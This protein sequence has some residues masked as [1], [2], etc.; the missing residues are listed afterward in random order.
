MSFAFLR[1]VVMLAGV[2]LLANPAVQA[3]QQTISIGTGGTGGVYYPLGG[4]MANLLSQ[5]LPGMQVT[6]EV[7]GASVDNLKFLRAGKMDVGFTMA[8]VAYD[9]YQ[10]I[11]KFKGSKVDARTLIS[12]Y[13]NQVQVVTVEG[14]GISKL[15]DLKGKR[16]STGSPGSGTEVLAFRMLE[17]VGIDKDK[18]IKRE[19]LSV[20]ESVNAIKDRKIDAFIWVGG[21]PTAAI[22]DLAA[23]PGVKIKLIDHAEV[24]D[25]MN[26]KYGPLYTKT[27]IPANSYQGQD[28]PNANI[29]VWNLLVVDAKMSNDMAYKITKTLMESQPELVNVHKEAM[30]IALK[31][32][33]Q[34]SP[35]PYHPGAKKYFEEKGVHVQ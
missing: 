2:L 26:K 1:R 18:D 13:P 32:Q 35:I 5:K 27:T 23:T 8:D 21:V 9:A 17:A 31:N 4:G 3:Q 28:K 34:T 33:G 6:A 16:V 24:L 30:N 29:S 19:R 15:A 12:L 22:T 20:A 25:A 7:T 11:D 10:G 14:T